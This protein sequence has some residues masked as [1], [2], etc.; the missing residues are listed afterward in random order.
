MAGACKKTLPSGLRRGW[1]VNWK[2]EQQF[3][4]QRGGF[5]EVRAVAEKLEA[6]H[7]LRRIGFAPPPKESDKPH[8]YTA[9]AEEYLAWGAA[10]GGRGGR[11]WS[12]VH[13]KVRK[14]HL[15]TFWPDKLHPVDVT[16]VT[17]SR[18]EAV[19]RE[20]LDGGKAGKTVASHVESLKS[21]C[22]WCK[23]RGYLD[24]DPLEGMAG[25]D[26]T[27][28]ENRRA[29]TE[30]EIAKLLA[31]APP[32]RRLLYEVA[33]C[34]GYRKGEL[35]A[36]KVRDLDAE[37]C[38]LPLA[39]E[40]TKGRRDARQPIPTALATKL[41]E[42]C[43]GKEPNER[44]LTF[45][46]NIDRPFKRDLGK[47]GIPETAPGGVAVFHSLRHSYCT[48]VIDSGATLT[49]A[50]RLMRHID[51]RMT[52]NKYSH[53]R[54]DRL[55]GVAESIGDKVLLAE[56]H[57]PS[58]NKQ[59]VGAETVDV[60]ACDEMALAISGS[61]K[62]GGFDSLLRHQTQNSASSKLPVNNAQTTYENGG[63][64]LASGCVTGK[65][66]ESFQKAFQHA[67]HAPSMNEKT[68]PLPADLARLAELWLKV[69]AAVRETWLATA[70]ALVG[71]GTK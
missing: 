69:P 54:Q 22:L 6:D 46:P 3:F 34:S 28:E 38:T 25:F 37:H 12:P 65:V 4:T 26:V 16:D 36:L 39:A 48:L 17:L 44:L 40:F 62:S 35:A 45:S 42:A 27:P 57:A 8:P 20:L 31:V 41:A 64:T 33:I 43:K 19:A 70:E 55:Q 49:E 59:A 47:A 53:A 21:F 14:R 9:T 24:C 66:P 32:S 2:G 5:K 1:F 13:Q 30:S 56:N 58:M 11:A 52:A 50:Q 10:Q 63:C 29:L 7:K 71:R 51:P 60:K 61:E 18:V 67:F 23:G 15:L 68:T